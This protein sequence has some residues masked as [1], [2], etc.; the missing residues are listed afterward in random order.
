MLVTRNAVLLQ[1]VVLAQSMDKPQLFIAKYDVPT[2]KLT[3]HS[4]Y[5]LNDIDGGR[6]VFITSFSGSVQ[7]I[8]P[9]DEIKEEG[10]NEKIIVSTLDKS[11]LKDPKLKDRFEQM[12]NNW[13]PDDNPPIM[14]LHTKCF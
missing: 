4:T 9:L 5:L 8:R 11:K 2:G 10:T 12:Q 1:C 3:Y 6:N 13:N 7:A 14:I